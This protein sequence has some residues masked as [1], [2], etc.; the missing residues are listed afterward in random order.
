MSRAAL[1]R[2]LELVTSG[3]EPK[4]RTALCTEGAPSVASR[5][6]LLTLIK[7]DFGEDSVLGGVVLLV[8]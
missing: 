3:Y 2:S 8:K 5:G 1:P 4:S 7:T 6:S